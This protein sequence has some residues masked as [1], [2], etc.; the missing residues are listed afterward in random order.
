MK[1]KIL[2]LL[3][4]FSS[5]IVFAQQYGNEWIDYSKP[6]FKITVN[7]EGIHRINNTAINQ[8]GLNF[9]DAENFK[10]FRDGKEI[11]IY[12]N[13]TNN[14]ANYIEFYA[15]PND[16]KLDTKLYN[17]T[18]WQ[19][20]DRYSLFTD[21]A[22][23]YLTWND[24]GNN[25]RMNNIAN[26][27]TNLPTAE[28]NCFVTAQR[29]FSNSF[30]IGKTNYLGSTA[31][32]N[33]IFDI[34]EGFYSGSQFNNTTTSLSYNIATPNAI[35][36]R[37]AE[38][39]T[40]AVSWTNGQHNFNIKSGNTTLSNHQFSG[41]EVVKSSNIIP[42]NLI[43]ATTNVTFQAVATTN[44]TN[45]NNPSLIEI[46]YARDFNFNNVSTFKFNVEGNN[47]RQ[48]IE[49][50]NF[51]EQNTYPIL[52]DLTNGY[53]ITAIDVPGSS[54]HRFV[55]PPAIGNRELIIR[56][57]NSSNFTSISN[58]TQLTFTN[59]S[60]INNQGDY[61]ILTHSSLIN[62]N[63]VNNYK[64][65]RESF[66]GGSHNVVKVDVEQLYHQFGYGVDKH[67]QSI[68]NFIQYIND[69]W[70]N[71]NYLFII[72]KGRE[73]KDF[74]TNQN[75]RN[76]CLIPT[77]GNPGSDILLAADTASSAPNIAIGRLAVTNTNQIDVYLQKIIQY[78]NEFYNFG[79]PNQTIA[80]KDFMKQ[81]IHLGGGT[82]VG[83]QNLFKAYL[84]N[85]ANKA[86]NKSWGAQTTSVFKNS[87]APIQTLPS[88]LVRN[89]INDGVSLITFFGHSY[90]GGF[91]ISF[92]DPENYSNSGKYPVFL[93]NGCN[94]G[95]IHTGSTS[96]SER[97]VFQAQKGAIAYL[98]T[99][100]LS[101]SASLNIYTTNFYENLS[102]TNYAT[103]L[104][105]I[106]KQTVQDVE[107]C[108]S[109][110]SNGVINLMVAQEMTLHGD[111]AI[112]FNQYQ[113]PDYDIEAH[114]VYFTPNNVSTSIDSF[115]INLVVYNLGEAIDDSFNVEVSRIYQNG[116]QDVIT[117]RFAAPYY[118]DTFSINFPVDGNGI[119]L[120][121]NKFNIYV[122][123]DDEISN[124]LSET[125]NYL[126]NQIELFIGSD[127]IFPIHPYEFAIVPNQGVTLKASTG[128]PFEVGKNYA[129]QIDT[130]ELF[131]NP[132]AQQTVFSAGG[133]V[134]WTPSISMTDSTVYYWRVSSDSINSGT[135]KWKYSSFIFLDGEYPGW[136]QSHYYQWQK[137]DYQNV[138][139]DNDREF[140]FIDIPKEVYVKTAKYPLID[141]EEIEWKMDGAQ[142]HNWKMNNCG[143]GVGFPNGISI[144]VI[145]NITGLPVPIINNSTSSS[146][147][148][149]GNIHCRGIEN[150]ITVANFDP[151]GNTPNN[152]PTPGIPWSN[153]IIDYLNN[154]PNDYY[155]I[156]Y[157]VNDP[158]YSNWSPALINYLNTLTSSVNNNTNG[159]MIFVY[160]K[161]NPGFTPID[162]IGASF[163]EVVTNTFPINGTWTDGN[164]KST[165]IGPALEWGSFHWDFEAKENPTQDN[166][167]VHIYGVN[168]GVETLL[169]TVPE[170]I[171]DTSINHIDAAL[172][173]YLRLQFNTDDISDRTPTQ[174]KYW[175]VLYK[176]P[177]EAA[178]NP[179]KYF[180]I[181][182]DTVMQGENWIMSVAVENVTDVDMDSLT[183]KNTFVDASNNSSLTYFKNDSLKGFDTLHLSFNKNTLNGNYLGQNSLTIEANPYE[184][185][186][187]LEQFH[188]NNFA[189]FNF[190]VIGDNINPLLDVSFDGIKILDGDLVSAKPEIVIQLKDENQFLALDDTSLINLYFRYLGPEGNSPSGLTR[191][192][193]SDINTQFIPASTTSKNEAK[194]LINRDFVNDGYYELLVKSKD[195]S[196]NTSS[197]TEN[198]LDG[199]VYYDYKISFL[200]ENQSRI[201]NVLN[202]PN[203]FTT[204]TQFIFTLTGSEI[205]EYFE[206]QILN[207]R[208][209]VI[210]Q[211]KQDELGPIHIGLNK[212][213]YWWDGTDE[214][215]DAL[216]NGVYFYKVITSINNEDIDH[217]GNN[218]VDK[219]FKK[220][221]GKMVLIR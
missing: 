206:I 40:V 121:L 153:L 24:V 102:S 212:T 52:Y 181:S 215:G 105:D 210:R 41:Y 82:D 198:R 36:N 150:I 216:A 220:G 194:V 72:G 70:A 209:T 123:V 117:K 161:N 114:N 87:S 158:N 145:N 167:S 188:F 67:P 97:F 88:E 1:H 54:T 172:Y 149:Y 55:L 8:F 11:P 146:Y 187:Q 58:L 33:S 137:D 35:S 59:F 84:N 89:R 182:Q 99:T 113:E 43:G 53:R 51:D 92:D 2:T 170:S 155:I 98:S 132:I 9:I 76:A 140:K 154:V 68:R 32:Y 152:H 108:C 31:L 141:F 111:P 26:N 200:V 147:G 79:D 186:Y 23:Y 160:Q 90:A 211:I 168:S 177:P 189:S 95:I 207:V 106:I 142:M 217:Y 34:G 139:L 17:D 136:N 86:A 175:R 7:Q 127:D 143:N 75:I 202:Y 78:D 6:H 107:D 3:S 174:A 50:Q 162:N 94:S 208:G 73:Y 171:L 62:S 42:A 134:E 191:V 112:P 178:I 5:F 4:L 119:G 144:A 118:K 218:Q 19:M 203:P 47:A 20:H 39:F 38:L 130:S 29:I 104:G 85:Y 133:V 197:S 64:A 63:E 148:P 204:R 214:Y 196:G 120:G 185:N 13:A 15:Y 122:D 57:D 156:I 48:F 77:F 166:Q 176:K 74:R 21:E 192:N 91:D 219:F 37:D 138:Y 164:F 44:S 60:N 129:F 56:A 128:N 126:L 179:K 135:F 183:V 80:K 110:G 180:S 65:H 165:L 173:P 25:L 14:I 18:A 81:I 16:G 66:I 125:N 46:K 163:N 159:P 103:S 27:L 157:S 193:F 115:T 49:I 124:E 221:I 22:I 61:I 93:A 131:T 201:S 190:N 83:Q 169:T 10:V 109:A 12:V 96:I 69:N 28:S 45:R 151:T 199:L 100:D 195:K 30:S 101:S 213:E 184:Q 116:S 205:P 71:A